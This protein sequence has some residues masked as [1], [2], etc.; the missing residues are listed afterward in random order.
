MRGQTIKPPQGSAISTK[1][2]SRSEM[3]EVERLAELG[4]LSS[5]ILHEISNPITSALLYLEQYKDQPAAAIRKVQGSI[6]TL[7]EYVEAARQQARGESQPS[8]FRV[9]H[10]ITQL[11]RVVLPLAKQAG[12]QLAFTANE[13][14]KLYGDPVKFQQAVANL[15][16]NAIEAYSHDPSPELV[17]PVHVNLYACDDCFTIDIVDWG[18]GIKPSQ[19]GRIFEPFYTT[20]SHNGHGLGIGLAI[21]KQY[22]TSDFNGSI[23]VRSGRRQGTTFSITIPTI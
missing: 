7:R 4:R 3:D 19:I 10:Q 17:K 14:C 11:K 5:S 21:V 9:N 1:A 15:I 2:I 22:I 13:D 12:V 6:K 20:K 8:Q 16:V 23:S 18:K